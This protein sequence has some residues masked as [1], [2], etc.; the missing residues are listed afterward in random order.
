MKFLLSFLFVT[1]VCLSFCLGT[2][3]ARDTPA[4][5]EVRVFTDTEGKWERFQDLIDSGDIIVEE[6]PDGPKY[7]IR[8]GLRIVFN[9]DMFDHAPAN[10][11][12]RDNWVQGDGV[13]QGVREWPTNLDDIP[14][15]IRLSEVMLDLQKRYPDRFTLIQGNRD[16]NKLGVHQ[17]FR[18]AQ[19]QGLEFK[20]YANYLTRLY[21]DQ[22]AGITDP[23]KL[24]QALKAL[25]LPE[26]QIRYAIKTYLSDR[27]FF[28]HVSEFA[29]K[30]GIPDLNK[31]SAEE[32]NE[33][34]RKAALDYIK[35]I[36]PK[37]TFFRV[38]R[39]GVILHR[40]GNVVHVHGGM[41]N[42]SF[43][44]TP[45]TV[46][47]ANGL[48][49]W[50]AQLDEFSNTLDDFHDNPFSDASNSYVSYG[51]AAWSDVT[52]MAHSYDKSLVYGSRILSSDGIHG[53]PPPTV[54]KQLMEEG[55]DTLVVG[56]TPQVF[57]TILQSPDGFSMVYA[58]TSFS[59]FV[60]EVDV[61]LRPGMKPTIRFKAELDGIIREYFVDPSTDKF[62]G[63]V[64]RFGNREFKIAGIDA[65]G[66]YLLYRGKRADRNNIK[67]LSKAN[68]ERVAQRGMIGYAE[69]F[70]RNVEEASY[71][72]P[73]QNA[74]TEQGHR[75]V[76][77]ES[78]SNLQDF[79]GRRPIAIN[80]WVT[81][82]NIVDIESTTDALD[83][84]LA[85]AAKDDKFFLINGGSNSGIDKITDELARKHNIPVL[86]MGARV[87]N[88]EG[89]LIPPKGTSGV[90]AFPCQTFNCTAMRK[91]ELVAEMDGVVL[92][93]GGQTVTDDL[94]KASLALGTDVR[95]ITAEGG[96]PERILNSSE[97]VARKITE[98]G[99][100]N[101]DI[102]LPPAGNLRQRLSSD[103][104]AASILNVMLRGT[105]PAK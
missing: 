51:D 1:I 10:A 32:L 64:I 85:S 48:T 98:V 68:M 28:Y 81:T 67:F 16:I 80:G 76:N 40:A 57:P 75:I 41:D 26:N 13:I 63:K 69:Y 79:Q 24:Q 23:E 46:Q 6:T 90:Y 84:F 93:A 94:V 87:G 43:L 95:M 25:D 31:L 72:R 104:S 92:T 50:K 54:R 73:V 91:A 70:H 96:S 74:L 36:G 105:A 58:D 14:A 27:A 60:K 100:L 55:V 89:M 103:C 20:P 44:W 39:K 11:W 65:D 62:V 34:M 35:R 17:A 56:H 30:I 99:A 71:F 77:I 38:I 78:V 19:Q 61:R 2:P 42:D 101:A 8:D 18:Q 3:Y 102:N 29:Y 66:N 53:L 88:M 7:S 22:L 59:P 83:K 5:I 47:R 9:G 82:E 97:D 86:Y 21:K 4:E 37:G 49:E 52:H 33:I 12:G 15:S 45:N